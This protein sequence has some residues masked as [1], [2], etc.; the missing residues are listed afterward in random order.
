MKRGTFSRRRVLRRSRRPA[1]RRRKEM[2]IGYQTEVDIQRT[3]VFY[4]EEKRPVDVERYSDRNVKQKTETEFPQF[5]ETLKG[6]R[7][8]IAPELQKVMTNGTDLQEYVNKYHSMKKLHPYLK[9]CKKIVILTDEERREEEAESK[10]N[11]DDDEPVIV[12]PKV[13]EDD[14]SEYISDTENAKDG[15]SDDEEDFNDYAQNYEETEVEEDE[16]NS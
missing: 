6:V 2:A 4:F 13:E 1:K 15:H 16:T 7:T 8:Y 3:S 14:E 9:R 5:V 11:D 12:E 10:T